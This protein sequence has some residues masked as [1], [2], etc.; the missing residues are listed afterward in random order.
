MNTTKGHVEE[1][2]KDLSAWTVRVEVGQALGMRD[3]LSKRA[4]ENSADIL[5]A[6]ADMVFGMD[7]LRS[8]LYHAERA[9]SEGTNSSDS[10]VMETMLYASGERQLSAAI[11]KMSVGNDTTEIVIAV[12]R[13]EIGPLSGWEKLPDSITAPSGDRLKRFG[14]TDLELQTCA[15][16]PVELVLEKVMAVDILKK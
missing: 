10:L 15:C 6:N 2:T 1:E 8:A 14:V 5:L 13:G 7:H 9:I 11:K 12:L 4:V 3:S 16:S